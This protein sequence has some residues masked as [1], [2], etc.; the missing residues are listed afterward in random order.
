MNPLSTDSLKEQV[1]EALSLWHR[2]SLAGSPFADLL[3]YRSA[4]TPETNARRVTNQLLLDAIAQLERSDAQAA[5]ILRLRFAD[6]QSAQIVANRLNVSEGHVFKKQREAIEQLAEILMDAELVARSERQ[7]RLVQRVEL[8]TFTTLFGM[9]GA[10]EGLAE[11]LVQPGPPWFVS[12]EGIGGIGKTSLVTALV[13]RLIQEGIVGWQRF[14]DLGWITARQQLFNAGGALAQVDRPALSR[15]QLIYDLA[16]QLLP[17]GEGAGLPLERLA[18]ALGRRLRA[19]PHLIVVDNLE[20]RADMEAVLAAI[21]PWAN[22]TKF[23]LGSR[24]SLFDASEIYHHRLPE[25]G[26]GDALALVRHEARLRNLPTLAQAD[27]AQLHSIYG[28]VG[29]NPLALRLVVGQAMVHGLADV[30]ADLKGA[31]G[32][33]SESLY[34]YIY[35]RA[36]DNLA[37]AERETLLLMPLVNE[38]GCD[39]AYLAGIA[40]QDPATL[41]PILNRLVSLNLVDSLGDLAARHYTI[42]S[43]TRSFLHEQVLQWMG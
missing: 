31:K 39:L 43:L 5:V 8:P 18:L 22:P 41:R 16:A 34:T 19:D 9:D 35:R 7:E 21:R 27:D 2:G 13:Q 32:Q 20:S 25:L 15:E 3:L 14:V 36:W 24:R 42:H 40:E 23:L 29:G 1:H 4:Q 28:T 37:E 33:A 17:A 30:M 10:V 6:D 26:R 38:N 11:I 12:V